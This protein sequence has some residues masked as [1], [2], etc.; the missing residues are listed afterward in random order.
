MAR[1][2]T[3]PEECLSRSLKAWEALR[4]A[5]VP[6]LLSQAGDFM[7]LLGKKGG[8]YGL[9][10]GGTGSGVLTGTTHVVAMAGA[11]ASGFGHALTAVGAIAGPAAIPLTVIN[12]AYH[13][14]A[15]YST[16]WHVTALKAMRTHA[17]KNMK[18]WRTSQGTLDALDYAISQKTE[19]AVRRSASAVP[20]VGTVG[21]LYSLGRMIYKGVKGTKGK[22]RTENAATFTYHMIDQGD[23]LA[24][25]VIIEIMG[26]DDFVY[27]CGL[28][29]HELRLKIRNATAE[30]LRST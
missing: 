23:L 3:D 22:K 29:P 21:T 30:K 17:T 28:F 9:K 1:H 27:L 7:E 13:A 20:G 26:W 10:V 6:G 8:S 2:V 16:V 15:V 18:M 19:K 5:A 4:K 14:K 25:A 11:T 24:T 12:A